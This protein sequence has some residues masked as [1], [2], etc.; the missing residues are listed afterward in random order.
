M[1]RFIPGYLLIVALLISSKPANCQNRHVL[2]IGIDHYAAP[3]GYV[4]SKVGRANSVISKDA[5]MMYWREFYCCAF[6]FNSNMDTLLNAAATRQRILA[7]ME[8]LLAGGSKQGDVAFIFFA[9]HGSFNRNS[10]SFE[11][12]KTDQTIVPADSWKEGVSDIRD[13]ELQSHLQPF[14]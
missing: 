1:L 7:S 9:G 12:N 8:S 10:L 13:K 6:D 3:A 11:A 2:L 4:S 5:V 14:P